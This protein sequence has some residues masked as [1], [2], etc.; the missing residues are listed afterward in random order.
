M[1]S[2]NTHIYTH[3]LLPLQKYLTAR[4]ENEVFCFFAELAIYSSKYYNHHHPT[5][6]VKAL[7]YNFQPAQ[8][9]LLSS[10]YTG[11]NSSQNVRLGGIRKMSRTRGRE[12]TQLFPTFCLLSSQRQP[13]CSHAKVSQHERI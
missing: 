13:R 3:R 10:P 9:R 7:D 1:R 5:G 8:Q 11:T 2:T 4:P 12:I 6:S